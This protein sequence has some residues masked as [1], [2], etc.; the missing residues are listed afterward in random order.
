MIGDLNMFVWGLVHSVTMLT[1][2]MG[3]L[4]LAVLLRRILK[5]DD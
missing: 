1:T 5:R 2:K 3:I 4:P